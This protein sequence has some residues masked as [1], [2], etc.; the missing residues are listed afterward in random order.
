VPPVKTNVHW[1]VF[2]LTEADYDLLRTIKRIE[3]YKVRADALEQ[4]A[5]VVE[6]LDVPLVKP[7]KRR[8]RLGV[9]ETL[10]SAL[11]KKAELTGFDQRALLIL[12]AREYRR[13]VHCRRGAREDVAEGKE[14]PRGAPEAL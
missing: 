4:L 14:E 6:E 7:G 5:P 9:P 11:K 12:A 8:L 3:D 2:A 13:R 10:Y 1:A